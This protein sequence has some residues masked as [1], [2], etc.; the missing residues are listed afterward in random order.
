MFSRPN[1]I[2]HWRSL[3]TRPFLNPFIHCY[4]LPFS[5]CLL[6]PACTCLHVEEDVLQYCV[7][8]RRPLFLVAIPLVCFGSLFQFYLLFCAVGLCLARF[9]STN[10]H[11]SGLAISQIRYWKHDVK[12]TAIAIIILILFC[13]IILFLNLLLPHLTSYQH[14]T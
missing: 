14:R 4:H 8:N 1:Q 5:A 11:I 9:K 3:M 7:V 12:N 2:K 13:L 10:S 6:A